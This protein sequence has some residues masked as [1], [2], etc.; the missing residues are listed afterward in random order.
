[1]GGFVRELMHVGVYKR[2]QGRIT[3]QLTFGAMALAITLGL[4]RLSQIAGGWKPGARW[5]MSEAAWQGLLRFGLPLVLLAGGVW[6]AYRLVNLPAF[7]D[8]LI[9]VEAEM[10]KVSWPTRGELF[11]ASVIVIF[12]IFAFAVILFG[13]DSIWSMLFRHVLRII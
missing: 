13:F 2:T 6:V 9:A 11:R 10:N 3:R 1:V 5:G 8:F 4:W 7:A 12:M